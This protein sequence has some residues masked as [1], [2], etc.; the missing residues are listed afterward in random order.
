MQRKR[1]LWQIYP[2][3]LLITLV[4]LSIVAWYASRSLRQFY[5]ENTKRSLEARANLA[6]THLSSLLEK[7]DFESVDATCK[8]LGRTTATRITVILPSGR[9]IGDSDE[10][11]ALMDN[12]RDRPEIREALSGQ[13]GVTMRYSY[14]L[15]E[16]FMYLAIPIVKD[17]ATVALVRTSLPVTYIKTLLNSIYSRIAVG[18]LIIAVGAAAVTLIIS[19]RLSRPLEEL[20]KGAERFAGG[21]LTHRLDVPASRETVAL[22]EAMNQMA[23]DL[24]KRIRTIVRQ[25]NEQDA[26]LSS[27]GEGL[28]AVDE[29]ERIININRAAAGLLGIEMAKAEGRTIY[30]M[31]RNAE[32]QRFVGSALSSTEPVEGDIILHDGGGRFLHARGT[33][34]RDA[35]GQK[36]GAV[37]VLT[38][39]T[40]LRRLE[41]VRRDFV[42]NVSH[43]L[44]TPIT[45]IKGFVET[46]IDGAIHDPEDAERFLAII[47]KQADRLS[48]IIE[49]LMT[50]ARIEQEAEKNQVPLRQCR[51]LGV[52]EEAVRDCQPKIA[53]KNIS[54]KLDCRD[55]VSATINPQLLEQA[56]VNLLDNAIK[57]SDPE[58]VIEIDVKQANAGTTISVRDYGCGIAKEHLPRLFERFY[59][60]DKARS[61]ELGGTGLGL[62]IVKHIAQAHGGSITVESSPGAGSS[63]FIHL[64]A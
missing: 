59:R 7:D 43:E 55:D 28:L 50:L 30:E 10:D 61:R 18:G 46:L 49:D 8:E 13:T 12:H 27:M 25:R 11:P 58:G 51:I 38:D 6:G 22:A 1:L 39:V 19:R 23:A 3:Y 31:I 47:A 35:E 41:D 53:E 60:V 34:L 9:V 15:K 52:L 54:I 20:R 29:N 40:S 24:D 62:A 16:D 5:T 36:V 21:D 4:S 32:L 42:A 64:P 14:T 56:I 45:S 37:V 26:V 33:T 44:K 48:A 2:T 57:Y 17:G 63:F